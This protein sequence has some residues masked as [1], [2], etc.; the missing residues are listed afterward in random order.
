M[1]GNVKGFFLTAKPNLINNVWLHGFFFLKESQS[2]LSFPFEQKKKQPAC[3]PSRIKSLSSYL[4]HRSL[5]NYFFIHIDFWWH[6][7]LPPDW[8]LLRGPTMSPS[9]ISAVGVGHP[10]LLCNSWCL[11]AHSL[12]L[13]FFCWG[14]LDGTEEFEIRR[15]VVAVFFP[16]SRRSAATNW[17]F[18]SPCSWSHSFLYLF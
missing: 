1:F 6:D 17:G 11:C 5:Y 10:L 4:T 18:R 13:R 3:R 15:A 7:K 8:L 2:F 16:Q 12:K 9:S 14:D